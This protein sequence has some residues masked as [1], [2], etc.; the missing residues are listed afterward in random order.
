MNK[1]NRV[2]DVELRA[3]G[4]SREVQGYAVVFNAPTDL[5]WFT[6]EIDRHAFDETDMSNVYLLFNH[7]ENNVLAGTAN[8]SLQMRI[9]DRGLFQTSEIVDTTVGEDSLKLVKN[10]LINKMSFAFTI[11][12]DGGEEWIS[13]AD[14][15]HRIIRKISKLFDVSLVTYPAYNQTSAYARSQ[16]DELAEEY[17][18]RK[19]QSERLERILNRGKNAE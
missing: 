17:K 3:A 12:P 7:D 2:Y 11:D 6:E 14:K 18:R 5:G 15:D 19:E 10:G 8:N 13:G 1:I 9:D 16:T 4:D